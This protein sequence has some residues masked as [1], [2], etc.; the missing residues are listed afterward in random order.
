MEFVWL[1]Q[2][3]RVHDHAPL[4]QALA[5]DKP[6]IAAY[7]FDRRLDSTT[8]AGFSRMDGKRR[9]FLIESLLEMHQQLG[10]LGVPFVIAEGD[11][12]Q[13]MR[14]WFQQYHVTQVHAYQYPGT[15][16]AEDEEKV[17]LV[18]AEF[19]AAVNL[20][21]GDTLFAKEDLPFSLSKLPKS[22]AGFRKKIEAAEIQPREE[23]K[24]PQEQ[25]PLYLED[26]AY[27]GES[28]MKRFRDLDAEI[29]VN[30]GEQEGLRRLHHY[31]FHTQDVL[32][33]KWTRHKLL[34]L[35]NSTK[36][37]AWIANGNLSPR[38]VVKE[39]KRFE[40]EFH[41][42]ESTAQLYS[43]LLRRDFYHLLLWKEKEKMFQQ[44]G[45]QQ[46]PIQWKHDVDLF[47]AWCDG[48]T[49]Y[50]L[51]DAAMR[52]LK[53]VG[54]IPNKARENTASFLTK[55]MGIDWRWGAEWF[56][57]HLIDHDPAN[58]YGNW[59]YVAGIGTESRKFSAL[60]VIHQGK[61][62]DPKGDYIRHW[63]PELRFVPKKYLYAP[64]EME[65]KERNEAAV[66]L[67]HDYP[68]PVVSLEKSREEREKAFLEAKH[69]E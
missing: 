62:H 30:G 27:T 59:Q 12:E 6:V 45:V 68:Y 33:Y 24:A 13:E 60:H 21:D 35:D 54:Y 50:P 19:D 40:Q 23:A 25:V 4:Q 16:E 29:M 65:E 39:L 55:N 56:E 57:A 32:K 20:M 36:L 53:S 64:F 46:L 14:R 7:L 1:R 3:L 58:N 49:G 11:T 66:R 37:S 34:E 42:T 61:R 38:R 17:R 28:L 22:F 9:R 63:L 26:H 15:E 18:A 10:K 8:E 5:S 41:E 47:Q 48:K 2:D 44:G 43:E 52:Q 31:M 69:H 51:V 67:G